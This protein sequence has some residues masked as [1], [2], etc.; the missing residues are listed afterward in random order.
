MALLADQHVALNIYLSKHLFTGNELQTS[1]FVFCLQDRFVTGGSLLD[2]ELQRQAESAM[3][4]PPDTPLD[5]SAA[6]THTDTHT[7][8]NDTHTDTHT[9]THNVIHTD[10]HTPSE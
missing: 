9:D 2:P 4:P 1:F 8:S 7:E 5:F 3:T 10:T 6:L